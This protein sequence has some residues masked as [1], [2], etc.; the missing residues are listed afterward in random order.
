MNRIAMISEHA[1]PLSCIGKVDTGG[2][3]V[4]VDQVA[5]HLVAKGYQVDV[6]TRH[7]NTNSEEV[8]DCIHGMRVIH[9]KAGPQINIIKEEMMPYMPEFAENMIA[10]IIK[11][12]LHY[13]AIHAHFFMSGMVAC[14]LKKRLGIPFVITFHALGFVRRLHQAENDKFPAGRM[15]AEEQIVEQ[16]DHIIAECPQ[17]KEDLL[18]YYHADASRISIIPCG[19]SKKEFYPIS[20]KNARKYLGLP[21][22]QP[23]ILQLGRMVPRKGIDNVIRAMGHLKDCRYNNMRL[24]VVGGDEK[25]MTQSNNAEYKRLLQI[26]AETD[27][28]RQVQFAGRK[29]R[30]MLKYYYSAA[31]LFITTPW[32]EPFGITPLEAMAC[33]TP[34]IGSNVGGIKYSIED[35][36]TGALVEP[37]RPEQLANKIAVMLNNPAGL[38][39]L[40]KQAIK[41]VNRNFTWAKVTDHLIALYQ[42]VILASNNGKA[43]RAIIVGNDDSR[44]A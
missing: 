14:E 7:D 16:A 32:Y 1:S 25:D 21:S 12:R 17:D 42:Q 23:V 18:N 27:I 39:V 4:Y 20:K 35:G 36:I 19:F 43:V 2:Q 6:F 3:N 34:V 9:I 30:E 10:F 15:M 5:R 31:D 24:I 22:N 37:D 41:H 40:G 44:A 11:N 8:V 13:Q 33:G 26:A 28:K 38:R 29:D